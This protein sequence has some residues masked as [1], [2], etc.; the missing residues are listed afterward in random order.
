MGGPLLCPLFAGK[1]RGWFLPR[2]ALTVVAAR[3]PR[4]VVRAETADQIARGTIRGRRTTQ[5]RDHRGHT[6]G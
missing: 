6:D 3:S 5:G 4:L 1:P 2:A